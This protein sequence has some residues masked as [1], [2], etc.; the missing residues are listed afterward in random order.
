MS[1]NSKVLYLV[2][3]AALGILATVITFIIWALWSGN[4]DQKM[5]SSQSSGSG[6]EVLVNDNGYPEYEPKELIDGVY[7]KI[8]KNPL[9]ESNPDTLEFV[10]IDPEWLEFSNSQSGTYSHASNETRSAGV[11]A[12]RAVTLY[13]AHLD[14]G[15][16]PILASG[17]LSD[18]AYRKPALGKFY[19][20]FKSIP[21]LEGKI[22]LQ[23]KRYPGADFFGLDYALHRGKLLTNEAI[24]LY[25]QGSYGQADIAALRAAAWIDGVD[26]GHATGVYRNTLNFF[27]NDIKWVKTLIPPHDTVSQNNI[28][29][30]ERLYKDGEYEQALDIFNEFKETNE[31]FAAV[32]TA[33]KISENSPQ[34]WGALHWLTADLSAFETENYDLFSDSVPRYSTNLISSAELSR[35]KIP[36]SCYIAVAGSVYD[37][38]D[39]LKFKSLHP[40]IVQ[41]ESQCGSDVSNFI[42][43]Q[44]VQEGSLNTTRFKWILW[45]FEI[46]VLE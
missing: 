33:R 35:N 25:N 10:S 39:L 7:E 45:W 34:I 5:S 20:L 17:D 14:L 37:I 23:K 38:T 24:E 32:A 9:I 36:A 26:T 30:V 11:N 44:P 42:A 1:P 21:I 19:L 22:E 3:G 31:V 6:E 41:L 40:A 12:N 18:D 28:N 16:E 13:T 15:L 2:T 4:S 46:G 29:T 27:Y 43:S 8:W